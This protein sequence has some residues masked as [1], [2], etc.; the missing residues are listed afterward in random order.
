MSVEVAATYEWVPWWWIGHY[1][2]GVEEHDRVNHPTF[3]NQWAVLV[4]RLILDFSVRFFFVTNVAVF[5][6]WL[7]L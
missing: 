7:C 4:G 5:V 6:A 2:S 1:R 3:L